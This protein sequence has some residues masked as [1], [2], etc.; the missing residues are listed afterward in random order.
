MPGSPLS[1]SA[2][3]RAADCA[4]VMELQQIGDLLDAGEHC[5][6]C[7]TTFPLPLPAAVNSMPTTV[8]ETWCACCAG[9]HEVAL[10]SVE[11]TET[12]HAEGDVLYTGF[13]RENGYI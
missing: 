8:N 2:V 9:N 3:C 5:A 7:H 12:V 6:R 13:V 4:G 10:C 11:R 1:T